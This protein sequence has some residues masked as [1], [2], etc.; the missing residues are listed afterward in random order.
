MEEKQPT[1]RALP[2]AID[3]IAKG[4]M[5]F[6]L[7]RQNMQLFTILSEPEDAAHGV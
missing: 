3:F 2:Q 4:D 7:H 6:V 1:K 5:S